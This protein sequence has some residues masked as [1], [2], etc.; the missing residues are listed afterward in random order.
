[1]FVAKVGRLG[2]PGGEPLAA[3]AAACKARLKHIGKAQPESVAH[4]ESVANLVIDTKGLSAQDIVEAVVD[5]LVQ[6]ATQAIAKTGQLPKIVP[7]LVERF[8]LDVDLDAARAAARLQGSPVASLAGASPPGTSPL[9]G[10]KDSFP[11]ALGSGAP[12]R[13][14]K[15]KVA[16]PRPSAPASP[17][18][19][20]ARGPRKQPNPEKEAAAAV[21]RAVAAAVKVAQ[22]KS[23][24]PGATATAA[25][26]RSTPFVFGQPSATKMA[27]AG[28]TP[29]KPFGLAPVIAGDAPAA[30]VPRSTP[31]SSEP[32]A[33]APAPAP[34]P[35]KNKKKKEKKKEKTAPAAGPL[36]AFSAAFKAR[37]LGSSMKDLKAVVQSGLVGIDTA[38]LSEKAEL[39]EAVVSHIVEGAAKQ[40]AKDGQVPPVVRTLTATFRLEVDL[41]AIPAPGVASSSGVPGHGTLEIDT[42]ALKK[43]FVD[44]EMGALKTIAGSVGLD[45]KGRTGRP[46]RKLVDDLVPKVVEMATEAF[47]KTGNIPQALQAMLEEYGVKYSVIPRAARPEAAPAAAGRAASAAA[48]PAAESSNGAPAGGPLDAFAAAFK[49]RLMGIGLEALQAVARS[50]HVDTAGLVEKNGIAE[51]MVRHFVGGATEHY[52]ATGTFPDIVHGL[53]ARFKLDVELDSAPPQAPGPAAASTSAGGAP[54]WG[55]GLPKVALCCIARIVQADSEAVFRA[56]PTQLFL[57]VSTGEQSNRTSPLEAVPPGESAYGLLQFALVCRGWRAAQKEVGKLRTRVSSV[58]DNGASLELFS[59]ALEMGCPRKSKEPGVAGNLSSEDL[60]LAEEVLLL[61]GGEDMRTLQNSLLE[62][63]L[64]M[65][66]ASAGNLLLLK[67]LTGHRVTTASGKMIKSKRAVPVAQWAPG[68]TAFAALGGHREIVKWIVAQGGRLST[69]TFINA[70]FSASPEQGVSELMRWLRAQS[71][72]GLQSRGLA[73][74]LAM[75][76]NW[77]ALQWARQMGCPLNDYNIMVYAAANGNLE[78]MKWLRGNGCSIQ[79]DSEDTKNYAFYR[80][81]LACRTKGHMDV[82]YYL[83]SCGCYDLRCA[84]VT[85][86]GGGGGG[87]GG[88]A[89]GC[90]ADTHRP[91]LQQPHLQHGG[92]RPQ[93]QAP[94]LGQVE[95]GAVRRDHDGGGGGKRGGRHPGIPEGQQM[96]L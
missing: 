76:N 39:V 2:A 34:A 52:E 53:I 69:Y 54:N 37:L 25:D 15:R 86:G 45:T 41:E 80:A 55:S 31:P 30:V 44:I 43:R 1:M 88:G 14:V 64:Y 84:G 20:A 24:A 91:T 83:H 40:Y 46:K 58:F 49:A 6:E 71:C 27:A 73:V 92:K 66:A 61:L 48:A 63:N 81:A 29:A 85:A 78:M 74:S 4:L 79:S 42:V 32:A 82:I 9:P 87:G 51:A 36:E 10:A 62:R 11:F 35:S 19:D 3:F 90:P 56:R 95:E 57:G 93:P 38:G 89:R 60:V 59:W 75:R 77:K 18:K 8:Q 70:G 16:S 28:S 21:G 23:G 12:T 67:F 17:A 65:F 68:T 7:E 26:S 33:A 22:A 72:P 13:K 50:A 5:K 96:Q 94:P 47:E